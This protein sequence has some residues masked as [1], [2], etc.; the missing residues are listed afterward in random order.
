MY[1]GI[2]ETNGFL[3]FFFPMLGFYL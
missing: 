3:E 2:M 1:N